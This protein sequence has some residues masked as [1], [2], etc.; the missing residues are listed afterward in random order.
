EIVRDDHL[1]GAVERVVVEEDAAEYRLLR[2][3]AL[4]RYLADII[5]RHREAQHTPPARRLQLPPRP[6]RTRK[7]E[8]FTTKT[9]RPPSPH[10]EKS[11]G[12]KWLAGNRIAV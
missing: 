12:E 4:R 10:R 8:F 2:F 3:Y 9:P 6:N 7:G 11:G 1:D 5:S